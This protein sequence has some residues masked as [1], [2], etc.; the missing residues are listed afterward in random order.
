M[1][2]LME[3]TEFDLNRRDAETQRVDFGEWTNV[4]IH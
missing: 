3:L 4:D 2:R 1:T